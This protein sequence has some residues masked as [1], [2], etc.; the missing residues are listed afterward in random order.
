MSYHPAEDREN[1]F[2]DAPSRQEYDVAIIGGATSGAAISFF[3]SANPD[4]KGT[5]L[6]VERDPSLKES[7]TRASN[8]CMR[9]QFATEINIKIAQYAAY[10]VKNFRDIVQDEA[11]LAPELDIRNF[12]YLYL[13]SDKE[14]AQ[15]LQNDQNMQAAHGAGTRIVET[16]E[17]AKLY[18]FFNLD[19]V[20]LG[21]LNTQ[22]EGEFDGWQIFQNLRR[23]AV[24]RGV[25][26]IKNEVVG[27]KIEKDTVQSIRLK[28]GEE[29]RIGKI[30]NAAG[31]RSGKVSAMAGIDLPLEA[32]QRYTYIFEGEHKLAKDVPLTI[33]PSGVHV[34]Q[35]GDRFLAGAPPVGPEVGV[36]V[37]DFNSRGDVWTAK[38]K[39]VMERLL[40]AL[41]KLTV[42][43]TWIGHYD[44]NT[45]DHNA[46][47]GPHHV[48]KNFLFCCGFSGHGSQQAP[49]CGRAISELITYGKFR[50][51]DL[52]PLRFERIETGERML[53]RMVI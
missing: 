24:S 11:G 51:L 39:P 28:T 3:L 31:T 36:D 29:V 12:G 41:G 4:F 2:P 35:F 53:E 47:I 44:F 10:F 7:A 50:T 49:A 19:N 20:L 48:I 13:A 23:I 5:I 37:N 17:I 16:E 40:P 46:I 6:V 8:Y 52:S 1:L 26:Y 43:E 33:D 15:T 21:S 27:I 18:P 32:R 42:T 34:R 30:V 22:D 38:M 9:Q 45:F 14:F 25:D